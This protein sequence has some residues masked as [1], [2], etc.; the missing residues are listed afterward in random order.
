MSPI[1]RDIADAFAALDRTSGER[2]LDDF[3]ARV[4]A[5]LGDGE[6]NADR[7]KAI[8]TSILPSAVPQA[9][10]VPPRSDDAPLP[11]SRAAAA[12]PESRAEDSGLHDIVALA[13]EARRRLSERDQSES[14]IG[15]SVMLTAAPGGLRAVAVPDRRQIEAARARGLEDEAIARAGSRADTRSS[16]PFWVLGSVATLAAAAAVAVFVFGIG[17]G[18]RAA[19]EQAEELA[20]QPAAPAV[21]SAPV[22]DEAKSGF[23]TPPPPPPAGAVAMREDSAAT[24]STE[25]KP[26]AEAKQEAK[27]DEKRVRRK[28]EE[29]PAASARKPDDAPESAKTP[30]TVEREAPV[31]GV[32][33][34]EP[35]PGGV[36]GGAGEKG[37]GGGTRSLEDMLDQ[38]TG[39]EKPEPAPVEKKEE[40]PKA[41]KKQLD[42]RDV[43]RVMG[44]IRPA[45][46]R[47][48][49]VEQFTGTVTVKF[50]VAPSGQVTASSATGAHARSKTGSCVAGAVKQASFPEFEGS[51][52][53]FTYPFMLSR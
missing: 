47:C 50:V 45:V 6:A 32:T 34:D 37:A 19:R 1:D 26:E 25:A 35:V 46:Q 15:E 39:E 7:G 22:E 52:I 12:T 20:G 40:P 3:S 4:L 36:E 10:S 49:E 24:S 23:A 44:E 41:E 8:Q 14:D 16:A 29:R 11:R 27:F 31:G 13:G 18:E 21:A 30:P 51:P 28:R 5:R 42:R 38:A 9:A 2:S 33:G 53:S 17:R 43:T 48:R